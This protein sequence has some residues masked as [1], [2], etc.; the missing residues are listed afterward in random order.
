MQQS[1]LLFNLNELREIEARRIIEEQTKRAEAIAA[2]EQAAHDAEAARLAAIEAKA[3][4]ERDELVRIEAAKAEAARQ[5]RL[6]LQAFEA[7]ELA[8]REAELA[9]IRQHEEMAIRRIEANKKRPK[10]MIAV[11]L[12]A[13]IA[14]IILVVFTTRALA[15]EEQS[16]AAA[17]TARLERANAIAMRDAATKELDT[18]QARLAE[19]EGD[20]SAA[21]TAVI[22]AENK[23]QRDK[24]AG[25]LKKA[26]EAKAALE[27]SIREAKARKEREDRLKGVRELCTGQAVCR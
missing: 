12:M 1:S 21:T 6:K 18:L 23:A 4:A 25:D 17:E 15:S 16:T 11:T 26:R 10:W 19:L 3:Q 5:D 24:A 14:T 2:R 9:A 27:Q 7:A 13:T 8:R 22:E 20:V